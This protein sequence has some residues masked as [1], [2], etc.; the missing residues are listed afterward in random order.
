MA[1]FDF[2][3]TAQDLQDFVNRTPAEIAE[4]RALYEA[5][6]Q[7]GVTPV[8]ADD[9]P[10]SDPQQNVIYRVAGTSSYTDY[11]WDGTDFIPMA[12]YTNTPT[13]IPIVGST[14]VI[15]AG[16]VANHG[17]AFDISE[18]NKNGS[19]L[20]TYADL[21][22]AL[23]TDG[24]NV[25]SDV[26]KGGMSVKFVQSN[27]N[28]Y[29]EYFLT[30]NT[31]SASE[32]DWQK[33]NLEE[34]VSQLGQEID[35]LQRGDASQSVDFEL[36]SNKQLV[37]PVVGQP[38]TTE[39][40][41]Y[42]NLVKI[43]LLQ[44]KGVLWIRY[45]TPI[46]GGSFAVAVGDNNIV[47]SVEY[48][49]NGE[50]GTSY[51]NTIN[52]SKYGSDVKYIYINVLSGR[53]IEPVFYPCPG[54]AAL[55]DGVILRTND[56]EKDLNGAIDYFTVSANGIASAQIG[57]DIEIE[58]DSS[59]ILA[60][61]VIRK[62][63]GCIISVASVNSNNAFGACILAD[64]DAK[65]IAAFPTTVNTP[66]DVIIDLSLYPN[67]YYLYWGYATPVG[68]SLSIIERKGETD[69]LE[70]SVDGYA[71]KEIQY[72]YH[73]RLTYPSTI[74]V[75]DVFTLSDA[76]STTSRALYEFSVVGLR[77][78]LDIRNILAQPVSCAIIT[79][80][81]DKVI[82]ILTDSTQNL[83]STD[84]AIR[85]DDYPTAKMVWF[86]ASLSSNWETFGQPIVYNTLV[87]LSTRV[88]NIENGYPQNGVLLLHFDA[89]LQS[90]ADRRFQLMKQYGF[91]G[92]WCIS[93]VVFN[94]DDTFANWSNNDAKQAYWEAIR[95]GDDVGLYP[96]KIATAYDEAGWDA[97]FDTA[98]ANLQ[99][100]GICNITGF[101]CG[102]LDINDDLLNSVK[103]HN[104]KVI[105]GG[106]STDSQSVDTYDYTRENTYMPNTPTA[107][108]FFVNA[109]QMIGN[110]STSNFNSLMQS[111]RA[112]LAYA[113]KTNT[114]VSI[115]THGITTDASDQTNITEARF[116]QMLDVI[117]EAVNNYGLQ[118]MPWR[119]W[120]RAINRI[121]GEEWDYNRLAKMFSQNI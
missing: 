41:S 59:R 31:W 21:A 54:S 38:I 91:N 8:A 80:N 4:L 28:K 10:V 96:A 89:P 42:R 19:T 119:T 20:A 65:I 75:G 103:K 27:D 14:D 117:S 67:A 81:E 5:L 46:T 35:N 100:H 7:T 105:R 6:T 121:D 101:M 90:I 88:A 11:M 77:G 78:L 15:T 109:T 115:F 47:K 39:A 43:P 26:R 56:R 49:A 50:V 73:N 116:I 87:G 106:G 118:V 97:Y 13:D 30:K 113:A 62:Y 70:E 18:Y 58:L 61:S 84:L 34:E 45:S 52:L 53:T 85:L 55:T 104:F 112:K 74:Q 83:K 22:A 44:R 2:Q 17:S 93:K 51:R 82:A 36:I 99:T 63:I 72:A 98:L 71:T 32:D 60:I 33:L 95:R 68:T 102:R 9:W 29:V 76:T 25:P 3:Q 23:G 86:L 110:S 114:A 111:L 16:G 94:D 64:A 12:T 66:E 69:V 92:S 24:A 1:N 107:E 57:G 79:D 40:T 108:K 120:Y 48:F 37:N